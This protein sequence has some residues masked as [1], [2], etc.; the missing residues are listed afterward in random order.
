MN[1]SG[2]AAGFGFNPYYCCATHFSYA[3]HFSG[4]RRDVSRDVSIAQRCVKA[5]FKNAKQLYDLEISLGIGQRFFS[6]LQ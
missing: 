2:A 4:C 1:L 5:L 3:T 6:I